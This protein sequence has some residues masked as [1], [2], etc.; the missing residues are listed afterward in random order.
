MCNDLLGAHLRHWAVNSMEVRLHPCVPGSVPNTCARG[1]LRQES[2]KRLLNDRQTEATNTFQAPT[3]IFLQYVLGPSPSFSHCIV[4][5]ALRSGKGQSH[6]T[7]KET[8]GHSHRHRKHHD[9]VI[10]VKTG[11]SATCQLCNHR[12][13]P[14]L[15]DRSN[16][17]TCFKGLL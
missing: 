7:D 6:F 16:N 14:H 9:K 13:R 15:Q 17:L 5:H 2:T 11:T 10:K 1:W 3:F 8:G 12:Q 4:I